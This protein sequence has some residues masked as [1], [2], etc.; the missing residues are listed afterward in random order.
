MTQLTEGRLVHLGCNE[1]P[2]CEDPH[3][4][5]FSRYLNQPHIK[6]ALQFPPSFTFSP[7]DFVL[8]TAYTD[9]RTPFK[10]TTGELGAILD[11]YLTPGLG[12]IKLLVLQG[13][14]DYVVNTPG[15]VWA[16]NNLRWSGQADYRIEAWRELE[17]DVNATGFWKG[18]ADRRLL[19]VGLDGA[20]HTV[21]GDV[22]EGSLQVIQK[23]IK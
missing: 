19:F 14:E 3:K 17:E 23:W 8:N 1:P 20:G 11:A 5:N 2:L 9:G 7:I 16:Y 22:R 21:P 15:Q 10:P 4:G 13:N 12:D 6:E 18:T